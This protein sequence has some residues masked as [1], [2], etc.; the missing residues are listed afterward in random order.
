MV[1]PPKDQPITSEPKVKELSAD[2]PLKRR[3]QIQLQ[4]LFLSAFEDAC[5]ERN[6]TP[7]QLMTDIMTAF[8]LRENYL[9]DWWLSGDRRVK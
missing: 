7:Q 3:F 6:E 9:P 2:R 8:L 5:R 4:G 1:I